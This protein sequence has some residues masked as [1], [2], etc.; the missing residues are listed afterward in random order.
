MV[1]VIA[2]PKACVSDCTQKAPNL[3]SPLLFVRLFVR[4]AEISFDILWTTA[5][6]FVF[7]PRDVYFMVISQHHI[8]HHSDPKY[9]ME[10]W[11]K[12]ECTINSYPY[13]SGQKR[14]SLRFISFAFCFFSIFF[15]LTRYFLLHIWSIYPMV[16]CSVKISQPVSCNIPGTWY[17]VL[18][19]C[20]PAYLVHRH[21]SSY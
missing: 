9:I 19:I 21:N 15:F 1:F 8:T 13:T 11:T 7:C 12:Y 6:F 17:E 2:Y 10:F 5:S 16:F 18:S 3:R 20:T 14:F 4:T